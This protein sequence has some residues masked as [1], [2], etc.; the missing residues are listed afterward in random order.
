MVALGWRSHPTET[1][2]SW[3]I[4]IPG[5]SYLESVRVHVVSTRIYIS[6]YP[7]SSPTLFVNVSLIHSSHRENPLV[8]GSITSLST[9]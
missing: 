8:F 2:N 6:S 7:M 3:K 4:T 5:T 9:I 1:K